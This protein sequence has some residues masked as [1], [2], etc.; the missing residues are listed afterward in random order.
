MDILTKI[1]AEIARVKGELAELEA[2]R[3]IILRYGESPNGTAESFSP[4]TPGSVPS[5]PSREQTLTPRL[6]EKQDLTG[7]TA[8]GCAIAILRER[9]NK[10]TH[11][12][13]IALEAFARGY[14]GH[15][16]KG[17]EEVLK[18]R[19]IQSFWALLKRSD[20]FEKV[21]KGFY[22]IKERKVP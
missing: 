5:P 12:R 18:A 21:G 17:S 7:N 11:A 3:K 22:R 14:R 10:A 1:D 13:E 8:L 6:G 19:A 15:N 9:G 2:A 16:L 20:R 4:I